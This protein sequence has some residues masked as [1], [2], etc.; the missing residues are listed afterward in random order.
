MKII[1]NVV[2]EYKVIQPVE[3]DVKDI[4]LGSSHPG[5][6]NLS[7]QEIA[8]LIKSSDTLQT[9]LAVQTHLNIDAIEGLRP[10]LQTTNGDPYLESFH[11]EK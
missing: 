3:V 6:K 9:R 2:Q 1:V 7:P 10:G 5:L 4:F 11:V 8:D